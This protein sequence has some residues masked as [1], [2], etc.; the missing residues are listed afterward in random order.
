MKIVVLATF[1]LAGCKSEP[2]DIKSSDYVAL[3]EAQMSVYQEAVKTKLKAPDSAV[4]AVPRA[5]V[6]PKNGYL[7]SCGHVTA[8]NI[9][10]DKSGELLYYVS[11]AK[12][13]DPWGPNPQVKTVD[14]HVVAGI[15]CPRLGLISP[16]S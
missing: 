13:P 14:N 8:S 2:Y 3:N 10:G 4:F 16:K 5:V 11:F 6:H 12:D 15:D 7:I 1:L 9:A